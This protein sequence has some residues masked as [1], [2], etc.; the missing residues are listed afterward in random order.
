M[1]LTINNQINAHILLAIDQVI[2]DKRSVL[3][4]AELA[5]IATSLVDKRVRDA[6]CNVG[7]SEDTAAAEALWTLLAR[8]LPS[9]FRAEALTLLAFSAYLRG[10]GPLAGVALDAVLADDPGHRMASMLDKALQG[11][12]R[13]DDLRVLI[14][15]I[16]AAV[17]V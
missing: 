6:L 3:T 13:P 10:E 12:I 9:P 8:V 7:D 1:Y 4:D 17:T 15:G 5:E 14:A 2:T 16:P 11:G